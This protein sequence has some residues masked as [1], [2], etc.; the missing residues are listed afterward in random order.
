MRREVRRDRMPNVER[1]RFIGWVVWAASLVLLTLAEAGHRTAAGGFE[2]VGPAKRDRTAKPEAGKD[3]GKGDGK[4]RKDGKNAVKPTGAG[5]QP[6]PTQLANHST[7]R[8][9]PITPEAYHQPASS[10]QRIGRGARGPR[11]PE[12]QG[13]ALPNRQ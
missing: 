5:P 12:G 10:M 1:S 9:V 11:D 4:D 2:A 6:N 7:L 13:R 8:R 3:V